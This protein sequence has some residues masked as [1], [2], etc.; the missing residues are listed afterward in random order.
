MS[1][2][3]V[4]FIKPVGM[5]GP[6]KIGTSCMPFSRLNALNGLSPIPLEIVGMVRGGHAQ[7]TFLHQRFSNH[8]SHREWFYASPLLLETIGRVLAGE[9]VESA[10]AGLPA[11]GS[12]KKEKRRTERQNRTRKFIRRPSS[13]ESTA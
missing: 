7:E 4:Y 12:I 3:F 2:G 10:C 5:S 13:V 9:T 6:I 1:K 8:H 11:L